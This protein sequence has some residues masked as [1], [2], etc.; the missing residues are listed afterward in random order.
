M[1]TINPIH[2]TAAL[3]ASSD[4]SRPVLSALYV[5]HEAGETIAVATDSY[6]LYEV[7]T[8]QNADDRENDETKAGYLLPPHVVKAMSEAFKAAAKMIKIPNHVITIGV[9][10][11]DTPFGNVEYRQIEG[12]FPDYAPI[13]ATE[14]APAV[15]NINPRYLGYLAKFMAGNVGA[16][17][18]TCGKLGPIMFTGNANGEQYTKK[19]MIMPLRV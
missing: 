4:D 8:P 3:A 13:M 17:M 6:Q 16:T 7:R 15:V 18:E 10:G 5:R 9:K 2:L 14:K 19:A 11:Y 12:K 1:L